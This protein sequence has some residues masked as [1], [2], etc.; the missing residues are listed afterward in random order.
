MYRH[1][2]IICQWIKKLVSYS[3][4]INTFI[5]PLESMQQL[6]EGIPYPY[7]KNLKK[8]PVIDFKKQSERSTI[9]NTKENP[10]EMRFMPINK[11]PQVYSNH[12]K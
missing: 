9:I 1:I 6:G 10:H 8:L 11:F 5:D 7:V 2:D 12:K 4:C 3:I